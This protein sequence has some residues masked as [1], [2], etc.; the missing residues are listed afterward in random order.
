MTCFFWQE[1]YYLERR[2]AISNETLM[3][4]GSHKEISATPE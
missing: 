2:S 1:I 4:E 3:D